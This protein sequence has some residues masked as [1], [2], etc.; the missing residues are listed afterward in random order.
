MLH[1]TVPI[2]HMHAPLLC[3]RVPAAQRLRDGRAASGHPGGWGGCMRTWRASRPRRKA[4]D[5]AARCCCCVWLRRAAA[6]RLCHDQ[7]AGRA[8]GGQW[9]M[10]RGG[11]TGDSAKFRATKSRATTCD[12]APARIT[13]SAVAV[14]QHPQLRQPAPTL[15]SHRCTPP[16][17]TLAPSTPSEPCSSHH[18][19]DLHC[20][21]DGSGAALDKQGGAAA[22]CRRAMLLRACSSS[23][24]SASP[25]CK[26]CTPSLCARQQHA[27]VARCGRARRRATQANA[28]ESSSSN[29]QVRG[30]EAGRSP[31]KLGARLQGPSIA[32][33]SRLHWSCAAR[34]QPTRPAPP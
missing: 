17:C 3:S 31:R 30:G 19:R 10:G 2:S 33:S 18:H 1:H 7:R 27:V 11:A 14:Y 32:A 24:S 25:G 5:R 9:R 26:R 13:R 23:S 4:S 15:P 29:V 22:G 6:R 21:P 20:A 16:P 34:R 8:G 28:S 12:R